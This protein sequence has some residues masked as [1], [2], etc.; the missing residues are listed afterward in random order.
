MSLTLSQEMVTF[1]GK[2]TSERLSY[3]VINL[4]QLELE[5]TILFKGGH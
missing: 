3:Q 4:I 1:S 2:I 5:V